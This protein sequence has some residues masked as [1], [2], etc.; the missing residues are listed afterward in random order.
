[1]AEA[2]YGRAKAYEAALAAATPAAL[3][4]AL[5]RNIYDTEEPPLGARRLAAYMWTAAARL[6]ALEA[7]ALLE[8]RLAFPD[9]DA[10]PAAEPSE[11]AKL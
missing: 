7:G 3:E 9:P 6:R 11:E 5:A 4:A 10:I 1:M 8:G 2:F